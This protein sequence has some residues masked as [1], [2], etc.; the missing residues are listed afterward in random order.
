MQK[1]NK[2]FVL[3]SATTKTL[4]NDKPKDGPESE[5]IAEIRNA[6]SE[7]RNIFKSRNAEMLI[8]QNFH[9]FGR[10]HKISFLGIYFTQ[11]VKCIFTKI[12]LWNGYR[13]IWK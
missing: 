2:P 9:N 4:T 8:G 1:V 5:I 13:R 12:D 3:K 10:N 11:D 6:E 7:I